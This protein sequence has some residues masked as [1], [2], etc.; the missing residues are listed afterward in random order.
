MPLFHASSSGYDAAGNMTT[1]RTGMTAVY[2]AWNRMTKVTTGSGESLTIVQQNEYDGANRRIR[3]FSDFDGET[4]QKVQ[5][6]YHNGQQ[7]IETRENAA[8]KYQNIWSPRYID[9][10][11]LRDTY[12]GGGIITA[13]KILYLSD[14]NYNVTGLVKYNSGESAWRVVERYSYTLYG[15]ATFRDT[16]WAGK[17][18]SGVFMY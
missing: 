5:D 2:D 12:S 16:D 15:V 18:G 3:I 17:K 10:M 13:E 8:I 6:D 11:V 9:A 1:L 4:P 14:A 7:V